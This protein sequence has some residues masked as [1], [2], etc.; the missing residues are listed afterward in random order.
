MPFILEK[1]VK[2]ILCLKTICQQDKKNNIIQDIPWK[3]VLTSYAF[4]FYYA[5]ILFKACLDI[6]LLETKQKYCLKMYYYHLQR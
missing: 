6:F 4:F 3:Q 1:K 2:F 5:F